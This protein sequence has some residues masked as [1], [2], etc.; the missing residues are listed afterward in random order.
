M[1]AYK[2][3]IKPSKR[4][5]AIFE[6]WL[7]ICR[8]LYNAGL[9]ERRDAYKINGLSVNYH[10]QAM[11]L[12]AVKTM[13]E[14]VAEVNAQVLQDTLRRLSKAFDAFFRRTKNGEAPGYPRFKGKTRFNSFTFPQMKGSFRLEGA[15]LHLSKIGSCRVRLS[16]PVEGTIKTCTIK[17]EADGWYVIFAVEE[18][19][20]RFI[21]K[22]GERVGIDVGIENFASLSTGEAVENP[23]CYRAAEKELKTAG[24]CVSRRPDKRSNR[25]RKAVK[26]LQKKHQKIQR[27]RADFHHKTALNIV[28]EFDTI[29][30]EDLN[31]KGMMKNHHLAKSISD[32]GWS[33]FISI[34]TSKAENAGR[35]VIK[36]SPA[37][38]SQDCSQ[39]GDRV[40]KSLAT[41]EHRCIKCG[42]VAHRDHNAAINIQE[43]GAR[44]SGMV[45]VGEPCEPRISTYNALRV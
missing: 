23:R 16:R 6:R 26:Q 3:K 45:P 7:D 22:T 25:R 13:R 33:Q 38:T 24:R 5:E 9:Q 15:K 20:C 8:E 34:L 19:Q 10:A 27:Q 37:Y 30:V 41:R 14:D 1:K 18:N 44:A 4:I 40:R 35:E 21:P 2:F 31:V 11:Q 32:A 39:C 43:R 28:R 36:V 42:F 12:P 17:R 29:A